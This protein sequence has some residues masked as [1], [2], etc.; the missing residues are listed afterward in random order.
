[1]QSAL[2]EI[3]TFHSPDPGAVFRRIVEVMAA[4][5]P[6][7]MAMINLIDGDQI[8]YR[9]VFNPHPVF[10]GRT[11]VPMRSSYCQFA[12]GSG[13]PLLIQ[14]AARDPR[15][16]THPAVRLG[17]TRYLAVPICEP[18]GAAIGTL[19]ILDD[20]SL[21]PLAERDVR[22]LS[23]LA[24]RVSAE[25]E[26]ERSIEE[27]LA[28]ERTTRERLAK[29]NAQL[30]EAAEARRRFVAAVIHD[31]R[32]PIAALRT[33]LYLLGQENDPEERLVCLT[34]LDE[35]LIA[36]GTMVD[37]LMEF[38]EIEAQG[39]PSQFEEVVVEPL[40][41]DCVR[42]F[43]PEAACRQLRIIL[44]IAPDLG[45]V[46]T[47]SQKLCR[48][49]RNLL[50]N[51][52]KFTALAD[53]H[54]GQIAEAPSRTIVVRARTESQTWTL[55]VEDEGL[56]MTE[57]VR[58]RIFEDYYR[59][60]EAHAS[61]TRSGMS[62]GRGLGLA[63]VHRFCADLQGAVTVRSEPGRGACFALCFP[64]NLTAPADFT[65]SPS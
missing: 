49:L 19:C 25:L 10:Q 40:L 54:R 31:L 57:A 24:M 65:S 52:I 9:E 28:Q 8:G 15:F 4:Q 33:T 35:R 30:M 45:R 6:G 12:T 26:R 7:T 38:A 17:L 34:M 1:M 3:S 47:D 39:I 60:P 50:S 42:D 23:L 55:E 41:V 58:E 44:D 14:D 59:G 37:E 61:E 43:H 48:V 20:H 51:A 32:Q 63:I 64:R 56:G 16:A 18:Q 2:L 11:R 62:R 13:S 29:L 21:E 36:L 46:H 22:F 5:Y 53:P 27:R